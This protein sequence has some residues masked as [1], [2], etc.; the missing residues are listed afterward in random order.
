MSD[1]LTESPT[2][3]EHGDRLTTMDEEAIEAELAAFQR[4]PLR[5]VIQASGRQ[6]LDER[7]VSARMVN[8]L[9]VKAEKAFRT[10]DSAKV[11][12]YV[13]K[14]AALP[15]DEDE[16]AYPGVMWGNVRVFS[17]LTD[18][19]EEEVWEP[20]EE[21]AWL[22]SVQG[23]LEQGGPWTAAILR[24][25]LG[26]LELE[27]EWRFLNPDSEARAAQLHGGST[28]GDPFTAAVPDHVDYIRGCVEATVALERAHDALIEA[29]EDAAD[30]E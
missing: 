24:G 25:C 3:H 20:D 29:W 7:S 12:R 1:Q 30:Q 14:A 13:R 10:G 6:R 26:D 8:N 27:A 2:P 4:R 9:L 5:D 15:Y 23:V 16:E 22:D 18:F 28:A 17:I 19:L 11:E 21:T